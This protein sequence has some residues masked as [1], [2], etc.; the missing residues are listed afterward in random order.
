M[1]ITL[2]MCGKC[3]AMKA[4]EDFYKNRWTKSGT[5]YKCKECY[6]SYTKNY[7]KE[8]PNYNKAKHRSWS[9]N[10]K[11]N[12]TKEDYKNLLIEQDFKC[13]ICGRNQQEFKK[14]L[15]VDHDHKTNK[16]RGLLCVNCNLALGSL[17]DDIS[18]LKLATNYLEKS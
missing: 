18:L 14:G 6:D 12:I 9:L 15:C 7:L 11:Y 2:K 13:A 8:H 1:E 10:K 16:V 5:T 3:L 17:F 4:V